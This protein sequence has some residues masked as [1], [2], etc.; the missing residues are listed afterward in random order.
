MT[1][2]E[3][4]VQLVIK[5]AAL[6]VQLPWYVQNNYRFQSCDSKFNVLPSATNEFDL[7]WSDVYQHAAVPNSFVMSMLPSATIEKMVQDTTTITY[8]DV[9]IAFDPWSMQQR[10]P[11]VPMNRAVYTTNPEQSHG[12]IDSG[13]MDGSTVA[14]WIIQ[15]SR[16]L[17]VRITSL[18]FDTN[19][20]Q[21]MAYTTTTQHHEFC[22]P[23]V[24]CGSLNNEVCAECTT[25][26]GLINTHDWTVGFFE[27]VTIPPEFVSEQGIV[28]IV[29]KNHMSSKQNMFSLEWRTIDTVAL[30]VEMPMVQTCDIDRK[31]PQH[32]ENGGNFCEG[33]GQ[34]WCEWVELCEYCPCT[35]GTKFCAGLSSSRRLLQVTGTTNE[36]K[37]HTMPMTIRN[38]HT[39]NAPPPH[40]PLP[41]LE[42]ALREQIRVFLNINISRVGQLWY[43]HTSSPSYR[44]ASFTIVSES[45]QEDQRVRSALSVNHFISIA[46]TASGQTAIVR[47]MATVS[48]MVSTPACYAG[49]Y[50]S[51]NE[52]WKCPANSKSPTYSIS[53]AAC[54]CNDGWIGGNGDVC[55]LCEPGKYK[56]S[57]TGT[58]MPSTC[59]M[60]P[61]GKFR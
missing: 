54:V 61:I 57:G 28:R 40:P 60:C 20:W 8:S 5:R 43:L 47:K 35:C 58:G 3:G 46:N 12:E 32:V 27:P 17:A 22:P 33:F 50:L 53:I 30:P 31:I 39:I 56:V 9:L 41:I 10:T 19:K 59:Q 34:G 24:W 29:L 49:S 6:D 55:V 45:A 14:S 25:Y 51:S 48:T 21:S 37:Y 16:V 23:N 52:C 36:H 2:D 42:L 38:T 7:Q 26:T 4:I 15:S 44:R 13:A 11:T 1:S 18:N